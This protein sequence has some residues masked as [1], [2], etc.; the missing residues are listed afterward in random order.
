MKKIGLGVLFV[1]CALFSVMAEETQKQSGADVTV[2]K[3]AK[4]AKRASMPSWLQSGMPG[5]NVDTNRESVITA[6]RIEYDNKEGVI[7]F[8]EKVFVD[9]PRFQL[10]AD[11]LL[12]FLQGTNSNQ[13]V[14]QIMA[15][16]NVS[17]TNE[18]RSARCDK[19][20]Y[21]KDDGQIV[22]TGN[23]RLNSGGTGPRGG[24]VIG[25]KIV[26]WL[27]DER[28]E[29][30]DGSRVVLPPGLFSKQMPGKKKQE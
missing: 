14:Q 16:G 4:K 11:R 23:A 13:D 6:E 3:P 18:N 28:L 20:V 24:E 12:L 9:D 22:M 21:T 5:G 2:A 29:V 8:D 25:N 10:R 15:I 27:N 19:A 26:F 7:L 17:I 1:V 30:M